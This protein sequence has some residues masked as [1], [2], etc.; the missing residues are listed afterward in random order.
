M[1]II[2]INSEDINAIYKQN[3]KKLLFT[4]C[5]LDSRDLKKGNIFFAYKGKNNNGNNFISHAKKNGA[6]LAIVE[7][8][9]LKVKIPQ[10]L[11]N[12][13]HL[14][15]IRLATFSRLKSNAKII[16]IT[17][18][19]GKTST[20]DSL[21][22][23]LSKEKKIFSA[24]KSFN[25]I[26]GVPLEILNMPKNTKLGIF[27]LG[28]NHKN[29]LTRLVK[30][31]KPNIGVILNVSYVHGGNFDNLK[32]IAIAKAEI[33]ND[34]FPIE[35]IILNKDSSYFKFINDKAKKNKIKNILT[36][37][38]NV[39]ASLTLKNNNLTNNKQSI[40]IKLH[41]GKTIKYKINSINDFLIGNSLAVM[42]CIQ[43]AGFN[44][45]LIKNLRTLELTPGRGN[46]IKS[47]IFNKNIEL[48]DHSYN[49]SPISLFASLD[50]FLK[51]SKKKNL[52]IVGDMNELG[53]KSDYYHLKVLNFLKKNKDDSHLMI[54]KI[55]YKYKKKFISKKISFYKDVNQLNEELIQHL[56]NNNR[57][58]IKGSN[59]LN[60]QR[61]VSYLNIKSTK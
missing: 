44:S 37:S 5:S 60:L 58:F 46:I 4:G 8:K 26:F 50:A 22:H 6:I 21:A 3:I 11:V 55:F 7:K 27:E 35:T 56:K 18:S 9:D 45:K 59:S 14:A 10:I 34:E 41:E 33:I 12:N 36:Y 23:V 49:S 1:T 38:K 20:K 43:A 53:K 31:L 48:H 40:E 32:D 57:I 13:S 19:V 17:G 30:I 15:L 61:L 39:K 51:S 2:N 28:M 29:E 25:N 16:A 54:G 52:I 42:A 47:T 24:R